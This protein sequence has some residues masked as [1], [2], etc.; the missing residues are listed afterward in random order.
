M[1]DLIWL[2]RPSLSNDF[3]SRK[4]FNPWVGPGQVLRVESPVRIVVLMP[5]RRD[6]RRTFTVHP[7]RLRRYM[8]PFHQPWQRPGE[9]LRFPLTL[10]SKQL[11]R[12]KVHYR[13]RWLSIEPTPDTWL[14]TDQLPVH[15]TET[16]D[17][18]Q[19]LMPTLVALVLDGTVE[20][21]GVR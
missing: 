15:L 2:H 13:V 6:P 12:G 10:I 8:V 4:M 1:G 18:R 7:D 14:P 21:E 17:A 16:Y 11:R 5:H 19:R 20:G 3:N 9:P